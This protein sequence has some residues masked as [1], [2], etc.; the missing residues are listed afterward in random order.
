M[1]KLLV[2][3]ALACGLTLSAVAPS[4]ALPAT[5]SWVD[6]GL[7]EMIRFS[8]PISVSVTGSGFDTTS[9]TIS[10][11]KPAGATVVA[12]YLTSAYNID[13]ATRTDVMTL[14]GSPVTFSHK[15]LLNGAGIDK[16]SALFADV[17]DLVKSDIDAAPA[18]T[19]TFPIYEGAL[20]FGQTWYNDGSE[21]VVVY[22][23]PAKLGTVSS[24]IIMFGGARS[25]GDSFEL[26]FPALTN[27]SVQE[28]WLSLGINYSAQTPV[29]KSQASTVEVTTSSNS[30]PETVT[31]TAGGADD[32]TGWALLSVGGLGDS[33]TLPDLTD[34]LA[35]DDELYGLNPFLNTGDTSISINTINSSFDDQI[36]QAVAFLD[37]IALEGATTVGTAAPDSEGL[38][39]TG[40]IE[41]NVAPLIGVTLLA[42]GLAARR[43]LSSRTRSTIN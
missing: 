28:I 4:Q 20:D 30:T 21:L 24:V 12:A 8:G 14:N 22:D 27:L 35:A 38:A 10:V 41:F 16:Y 7:F 36:F 23:D 1:K 18:G 33:L 37:G 25:I 11:D 9:G 6:A 31:T 43:L 42:G 40:A 39:N 19:M 26:Q 13:S 29:N 3:G 34:P 15:S 5:T 2:M 17:T 32:A